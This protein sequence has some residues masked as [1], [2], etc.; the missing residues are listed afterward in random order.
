MPRRKT[1]CAVD[2]CNATTNGKMCRPHAT[3][4]RSSN[5]TPQEYRRGWHLSKKYGLTTEDF[6]AL[7]FAFRGK[8]GICGIDMKLPTNTRGQAMD[9]VAIDHN[10]TTGRVRGLLCNVCNK[11]LGMF[12]DD[13]DNLKRAISW[14]EP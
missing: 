2:G 9:V 11:G 13:I 6:D 5:L 8:C 14:L 4:H 10:H 7:W 3:A 1:I 12:R